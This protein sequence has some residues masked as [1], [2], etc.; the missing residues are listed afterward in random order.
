[1]VLNYFY[2][3]LMPLIMVMVMMPP[4]VMMAMA[5]IYFHIT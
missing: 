1:M 5:M 3:M 4:H 2:P